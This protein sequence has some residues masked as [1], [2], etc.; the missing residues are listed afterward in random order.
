MIVA[1]WA[2]YL[3]PQWIRR[4]DTFAESRDEDRHSGSLRVLDPRRRGRG[5]RSTSPLL[6][7]SARVSAPVVDLPPPVPAQAGAPQ[8]TEAEAGAGGGT[9][10]E[11]VPEPAG[12][13]AEVGAG[14]R[15][16]VAGTGEIGVIEELSTETELLAAAGGTT[17]ITGVRAV[18]RPAGP[19]R[20]VDG[21][22]G[23]GPADR[24]GSDPGRPESGRSG[25]GDPGQRG[26][27]QDGPGHDHPVRAAQGTGRPPGESVGEPGRAA[28][29]GGDGPPSHG[30]P[31]KAAPRPGTADATGPVPELSRPS[32]MR[33]PAMAPSVRPRAVSRAAAGATAARATTMA[34]AAARRRAQVLLGL[35][36]ATVLG[37]GAVPLLGLSALIAAMPTLLLGAYLAMLRTLAVRRAARRATAAP[38][39][40]EPPR[41]TEAPRPRTTRP[42]AGPSPVQAARAAAEAAARRRADEAAALAEGTDNAAEKLAPASTW[43]PVPVP[44]PTYT[45]KPMAPR[46][47]PAPLDFATDGHDGAAPAAGTGPA[48][49]E[50]ADGTAGPEPD[51]EANGT[52][53]AGPRP[54]SQRWADGLDLDAVLARRRAVNG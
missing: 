1:L 22:P 6:G 53:T 35:V 19:I 3:L 24:G 54:D 42:A 37:W 30:V 2:A 32:R 36:T 34:R 13:F 51:E 8:L 44:P 27:G 49:G 23:S 39:P 33:R 5:G 48:S 18:P 11:T 28:G 7:P 20:L 9:C 17:P 31:R 45:M 29:Q 14:P 16:G 25:T 52:E 21:R 10:R 41:D 46:A 38:R 43:D 26:P 4:R 50:A 15:S 40:A 47:E 12:K